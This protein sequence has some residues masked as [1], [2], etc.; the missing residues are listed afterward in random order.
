MIEDAEGEEP[1]EGDIEGGLLSRSA[2]PTEDAARP[3]KRAKVS[4]AAAAAAASIDIADKVR[5][6]RPPTLYTPHFT[7]PCTPPFR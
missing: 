3:R 7:H 1:G 4:A 2:L 5:I 6:H